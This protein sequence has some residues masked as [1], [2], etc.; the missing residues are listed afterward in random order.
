MHQE[1]KKELALFITTHQHSPGLKF[2][3]LAISDIF[4]HSKLLVLG[5]SNS[6][7]K[8]PHHST[9]CQKCGAAEELK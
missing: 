5:N 4:F 9:P 1:L 7:T 3:L 6:Q 2:G 8:V